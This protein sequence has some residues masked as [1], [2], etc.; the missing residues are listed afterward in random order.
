[1]GLPE[2]SECGTME[3][4]PDQSGLCPARVPTLGAGFDSRL[5]GALGALFSGLPANVKGL[6][7]V[8]EQIGGRAMSDFVSTREAGERAGF[9][10]AHVSYLLRKGIVE[11]VKFGWSWAVYWPSMEA[12][13]ATNPRPGP[14]FRTKQAPEGA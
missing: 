9:S 13:L 3:A 2:E 7:A 1:M 14:K 11:G 8:M 10:E 12:Y 6:E 5:L 4:G